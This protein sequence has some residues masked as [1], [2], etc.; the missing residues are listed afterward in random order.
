[1]GTFRGE[2]FNSRRR[3]HLLRNVREGHRITSGTAGSRYMVGGRVPNS[4]DVGPGLIIND[5]PVLLTDDGSDP[6]DTPNDGILTGSAVVVVDEA[7]PT[8]TL[9]SGSRGKVSWPDGTTD[10][11]VPNRT[12]TRA[13]SLDPG[14]SQAIV[15]TGGFVGYITI[16]RVVMTISNPT[17]DEDAGNAGFLVD[18]TDGG[19]DVNFTAT[20]ADGTA[21]AGIDYTATTDTFTLTGVDNH[22]V[23]VPVIDRPGT[24]GSRQF[25]LQVTV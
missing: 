16:I 2:G 3:N 11:L 4:V 23:Q 1:M 10:V 17:V 15:R 25:A 21:V 19:S 22:T 5:T 20:T 12:T 7:A 14:D 13:V 9:T 6:N 8:F 18:R 24:Q